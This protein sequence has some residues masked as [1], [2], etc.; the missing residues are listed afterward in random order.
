MLDRDPET[1]E[2]V[3]WEPNNHIDFKIQANVFQ[4]DQLIP[5]ISHLALS[6]SDRKTKVAACELLHTII[7]FLIGTHKLST[8]IWE[9]LCSTIIELG[10]DS[11]AAVQEIYEPLLYQIVHY[12]SKPDF[13]NLEGTQT[14][15]E[16]L[17]HLISH[18]NNNSIQDLSAK[19]LREFVSW[20]LRHIPRERQGA[21]PA[22]LKTLFNR[23]ML[24]CTD[25]DRNKRKAAL[26]TFNNLYR[27][28]RNERDLVSELWLEMFYCYCTNYLMS[29]NYYVEIK[30]FCISEHSSSFA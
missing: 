8:V 24:Y 25:A 26:L 30:Y 18:P 17:L 7:L 10:C 11:D 13:I 29:E 21:T 28:T 19:L 16:A 1:L 6:S 14:F 15:I 2:L 20:S 12:L 5:R 27:I 22:N 4:L 9:K 23:L 3:K